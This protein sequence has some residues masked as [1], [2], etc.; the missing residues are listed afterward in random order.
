MRVPGAWLVEICVQKSLT[1]LR[2]EESFDW[3][4]PN[5]V[6]FIDPVTSST[7]M[8]SVLVTVICA[9]HAI[10]SGTLVRP[11]IAI[12]VVG[13]FRLALPLIDKSGL[14]AMLKTRFR[15]SYRPDGKFALNSILPRLMT[16]C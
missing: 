7:I 1:T 8:M 6:S 12:K 5:S 3:L 16:V 11:K 9:L 4:S 13:S 10:D 15:A 14:T 2:T